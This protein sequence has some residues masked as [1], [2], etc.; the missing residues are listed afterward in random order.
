MNDRV[1]PF[2][3]LANPP[4]FET[5]PRKEKPVDEEAIAI[6][7]K[8]NNFPTRQATKT[9]KAERRKPR[10][11]RTGRNQQFNAK[12]TPETIAKIYKL[13]DERKVMISELLELAVAAL[14]REGA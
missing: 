12:A 7:A 1:N 11:H 6:I 9:P 14:E 2:A 10:L 3:V 13:A 8:E 4:S 5:K